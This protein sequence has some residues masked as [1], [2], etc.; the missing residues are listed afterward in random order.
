MNEMKVVRLAI[1]AGRS[2]HEQQKENN[3]RIALTTKA[4][5]W[6]KY[7]VAE[8]NYIFRG[9]RQSSPIWSCPQESSSQE[10][11]QPPTHLLYLLMY[12]YYITTILVAACAVLIHLAHPEITQK[13]KKLWWVYSRINLAVHLKQAV[14]F[15]LLSFSPALFLVVYVGG[16]R[17]DYFVSSRDYTKYSLGKLVR[18][19]SG[20]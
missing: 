11:I 4:I 19:E 8:Y 1:G 12:F 16:R 10:V 15:F 13:D 20:V 3:R 17:C 6:P 14:D 2:E 9:D 5:R 7:R 18:R